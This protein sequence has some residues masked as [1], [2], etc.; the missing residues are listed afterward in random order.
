M[1]DNAKLI[2]IH[3]HCSNSGSDFFEHASTNVT[4]LHNAEDAQTLNNSASFTPHVHI[5]EKIIY[6]NTVTIH[7][8]VNI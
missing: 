5:T 8:K 4:D 3:G 2:F 7:H 6:H 1:I